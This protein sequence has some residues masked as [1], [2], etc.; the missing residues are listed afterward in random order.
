[1]AIKVTKFESK[2]HKI[3]CDR[4]ATS[5]VIC[6]FATFVAWVVLL[7]SVRTDRLG[8]NSTSDHFCIV[9]M[10]WSLLAHTKFAKYVINLASTRACKVSNLKLPVNREILNYLNSNL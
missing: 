6:H 2:F 3:H 8:S 4:M 1:M 10:S 9:L 7:S 5:K